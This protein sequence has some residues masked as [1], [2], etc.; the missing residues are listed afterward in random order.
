[1][2]PKIKISKFN[3]KI[4]YTKNMVNMGTGRRTSASKH[5]NTITVFWC[6]LGSFSLLLCTSVC[7]LLYCSNNTIL[8]QKPEMLE[9]KKCFHQWVTFATILGL[10]LMEFGALGFQYLS[11]LILNDSFSTFCDAT[12]YESSSYTC[13]VLHQNC[14]ISMLVPQ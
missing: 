4:K 8:P 6:I 1:M 10:Q 12:N 2:V 5:C 13:T 14:F 11:T 9:M 3:S 7:L